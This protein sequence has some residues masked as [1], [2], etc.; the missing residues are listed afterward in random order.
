MQSVMA[1]LFCAKNCKI[2]KMASQINMEDVGFKILKGVFVISANIPLYLVIYLNKLFI[3]RCN[4]VLWIYQ[5]D[6]E[7]QH[8]CL[9]W[10]IC[11]KPKDFRD[12]VR[13][14]LETVDLCWLTSARCIVRFDWSKL[15]QICIETWHMFLTVA[16]SH[17]LQFV[18]RLKRPTSKGQTL[19]FA[20]M[21]FSQTDIASRAWN[22][23][24]NLQEVQGQSWHEKPYFWK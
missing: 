15:T 6:F 24:S 5:N 12:Y 14:A 4:I 20:T 2:F 8:Q 19:N 9:L 13:A 7:I 11:Q 18:R 1:K 16:F 3:F 10:E 23:L 21:M 22:W 17:I